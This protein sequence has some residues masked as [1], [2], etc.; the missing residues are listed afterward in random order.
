MSRNRGLAAGVLAFL[1]FASAIV[2]Q[3]PAAAQDSTPEPVGSVGI[4][5]LEAPVS[6]QDDPRA[7]AY[8]IDNLPPGTT[9]TRRIEVS[10]S[11]DQE[12]AISLY[13]AAASIGDGD[14]G[15]EVAEDRTANELTTWMSV[16]PTD[17]TLAPNSAAEAVV[18]IAVPA[19]APEGEQYAVVWAQTAGA[20]DATGIQNV[21]RVGIRT[22]LSVGPGNGPPADLSIDSV[23]AERGEDGA[24]KVVASVT[25]TGGRALDPSGTVTLSGGPGGIATEPIQGSSG[26][27]APGQSGQVLF[28]LDPALPAGPWQAAVSVASGLVNKSTTVDLTFPEQGS[29]TASTGESGG[30]P[31]WVWIVVVAVV[32]V[33]AAGAALAVRRRKAD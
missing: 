4:R 13:P 31:V 6:L 8:I 15:F 14:G 21:S 24:P 1:A 33:A 32:V 10:N 17:V 22:Y 11:S 16:E 28:T 26:S 3:A 27:I 23:T 2:A 29:T 25:N 5:L 19:D 20:P 9:I 18:T 30:V 12:Q 7:L